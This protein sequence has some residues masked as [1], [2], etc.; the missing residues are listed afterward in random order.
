MALSWLKPCHFRGTS[1]RYLGS[2]AAPRADQSGEGPLPS[3]AGTDSALALPRPSWCLQ[4]QLGRGANT[5]CVAGIFTEACS[6]RCGTHRRDSKQAAQRSAECRLG[7]E[8]TGLA[9]SRSGHHGT[10]KE[11]RRNRIPSFSDVAKASSVSD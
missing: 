11:E 6:S 2:P 8:C 1:G 4:A 9:P 10:R 7:S 5:I 3:Q